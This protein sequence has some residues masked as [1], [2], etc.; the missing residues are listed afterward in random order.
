[1]IGVDEADEFRKY[2]TPHW[3]YASH[4]SGASSTPPRVRRL[5][6]SLSRVLF[7]AHAE[8]T[9]LAVATSHVG[10]FSAAHWPSHFGTPSLLHDDPFLH[11]TQYAPDAVHPGGHCWHVPCVLELTHKKLMDA[12]PMLEGHV[13]LQLA[14]PTVR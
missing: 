9:D 13:Q 12:A 5:W 3:K 2:P 14:T 7:T 10:Y 11:S 6:P 4:S 1:V 8:H